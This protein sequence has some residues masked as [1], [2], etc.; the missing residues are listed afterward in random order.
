MSADNSYDSDIAKHY[1]AYRPP[2]HALILAQCL[3]GDG[4]FKH[5]LDIG[6][7]TGQSTI[8]LSHYC[9]QVTG[10]EPSLK[11]LALANPSA[12]VKYLHFEGSK[13][14][15]PDRT[16]DIVTF[17]GSLFYAKSQLLFDEM[18]RVCQ[19][20][21]TIL[22]YDFEILFDQLDTELIP[23]TNSSNYDHSTN[24][25][26]LTTPGLAMGNSFI[27]TISLE[28]SP[29]N[30]AHLLL[31]SQDL[32]YAYQKKYKVS[33]PFDALN[34]DLRAITAH[35]VYELPVNLYATKYNYSN[36]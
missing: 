14:N 23:A 34:T 24:F 28:I 19:T 17:A 12:N 35:Q 9:T 13:I 7:G 22:V 25:S 29:T 32:H 6:S 8:A 18:A 27:H 26:G 4:Q 10:I 5:G 16:F 1:S 36:R 11:M 33:E 21:A 20:S 2:L 31:S 30:L 15:S 3:D